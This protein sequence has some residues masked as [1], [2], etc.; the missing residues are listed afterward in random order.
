MF[1]PNDIKLLQNLI[2]PDDHQPLY[3][4]VLDKREQEAVGSYLRLIVENAHIPKHNRPLQTIRIKKLFLPQF[5]LYNF[6]KK[7]TS[8]ITGSYELRLSLS[9]L[10]HKGVEHDVVKYFFAIP[11]AII[12]S[13]YRIIESKDDV[14]NLLTF[15][16]PLS[17]SMLLNK[18]FYETNSDRKFESS[19]FQPRKLVLAVA[20]VTKIDGGI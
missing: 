19:G 8:S 5:N 17:R 11:H 12:N 16:K 6:V 4:F 14:D 18:V 9:F 7:L 20:W 15:L 1:L 2:L 13:D 10:V 3:D